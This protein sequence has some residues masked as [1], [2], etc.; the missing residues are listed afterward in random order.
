MTCTGD[1]WCVDSA[2]RGR[3]FMISGLGVNVWRDMVVTCHAGLL[4]S[5]CGVGERTDADG[6]RKG[7]CVRLHETGEAEGVLGKLEATELPLLLPSEDEDQPGTSGGTSPSPR[8]GR[9]RDLNLGACGVDRPIAFL[10]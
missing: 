6:G 4:T 2:R 3:G 8:V 7:V 5:Y 1:G 10:I 9:S